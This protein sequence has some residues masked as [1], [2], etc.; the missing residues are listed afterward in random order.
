[1]CYR[2][3]KRATWAYKKQLEEA[4][5]WVPLTVSEGLMTLSSWLQ[6]SE[7]GEQACLSLNRLIEVRPVAGCWQVNGMDSAASAEEYDKMF[8]PE[9]DRVIKLNKE[10]GVLADMIHAASRSPTQSRGEGEGQRERADAGDA[11]ATVCA[12]AR[13]RARPARSTSS[14]AWSQPPAAAARRVGQQ[15]AGPRRRASW[16]CRA[17]SR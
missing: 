5:A 11:G 13:R 16:G 8:C 3:A 9:M 6:Q 15:E 1:M 12:G 7:R 2:Q 4:E 14:W 10:S 17:A